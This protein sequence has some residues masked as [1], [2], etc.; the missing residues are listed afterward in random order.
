[1]R[2]INKD[3]LIDWLPDWFTINQ[4]RILA[5]VGIFRSAFHVLPPTCQHSSGIL[6]EK[7][8]STVDRFHWCPSGLSPRPSCFLC[9]QQITISHIS[10]HF[11]ADDTQL[12]LSSPSSDTQAHMCSPCWADFFQSFFLSKTHITIDKTRATPDKTAETVGVT[13]NS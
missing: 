6:A 3:L 11:Y 12:S 10:Y 7:S 5:N 4:Q 13:L 2:Y 8:V 1:M 9:L